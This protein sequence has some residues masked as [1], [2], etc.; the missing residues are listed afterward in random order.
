MNGYDLFDF[1][2]EFNRFSLELMSVSVVLPPENRNRKY[3]I[4][5]VKHLLRCENNGVEELSLILSATSNLRHT[6]SV[7]VDLL[8]VYNRTSQEKIVIR[9]TYIQPDK[10]IL[11]YNLI[12]ALFMSKFENNGISEIQLLVAEAIEGNS[13]HS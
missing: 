9:A 7:L 10:K 1:L 12:G 13:F 11:R 6:A 5:T 3:H 8:K 2:D 4:K